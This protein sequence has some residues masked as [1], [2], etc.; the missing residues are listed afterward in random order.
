MDGMKNAHTF[1]VG[2]PAEERQVG[3]RAWIGV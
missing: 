1:L 2:I 3:R